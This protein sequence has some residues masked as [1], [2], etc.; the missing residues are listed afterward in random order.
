MY[1]DV[2]V[3]C[4]FENLFCANS[5]VWKLAFS[6]QESQ[7]VLVSVHREDT[8]CFGIICPKEPRDVMRAFRNRYTMVD[9]SLNIVDVYLNIAVHL[10]G[11]W[12]FKDVRL[13]V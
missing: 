10:A 2:G 8:Q 4:F 3:G 11:F 6:E 13:R 1:V 7:I 12:I 9:S 5:V